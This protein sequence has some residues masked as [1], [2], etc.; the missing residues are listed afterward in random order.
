MIAGRL[1]LAGL[2]LVVAPA[3]AQVTMDTGADEVRAGGGTTSTVS[4]PPPTSTSVTTTT[5]VTS[6]IPPTSSTSSTT[7][8]STTTTMAAGSDLVAAYAC[9]A[10]MG[11][12]L[13]DASGFGN[14]GAF[15]SGVAWAPGRF[16]A[17]ALRFSGGVVTVPDSPSLGATGALTIE[18]WIHLEPD[19][20]AELRLLAHLG[21]EP[22]VP[23]PV[24][25]VVMTMLSHHAGDRPTAAEATAILEPLAAEFAGT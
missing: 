2:L 14:H 13:T 5:A 1:I 16:G 6:S 23:E 17:G 4:I 15:G 24:A 9:D 3:V 8:S 25:R 11:T 22:H 7:T 18:A 20:E 12:T 10:G 21:L 19:V